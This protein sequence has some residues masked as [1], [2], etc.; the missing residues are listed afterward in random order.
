MAGR[1]MSNAERFARDLGEGLLPHAMGLAGAHGRPLEVHCLT[2]L[3]HVQRIEAMRVLEGFSGTRGIVPTHGATPTLISGT[4]HGGASL[5]GD[6]A[7]ELVDAARTF[8]RKQMFRFRFLLELRR[9][10][11]V[12]SPAGY[13][14]LSNRHGEALLS[15]AALVCQDVSHVEM[16]LPLYDRENVVFCR[17]DLSD[18]RGTVGELLSDDALRI[19]IAQA[20]RRSYMNWARD[21][22]RHLDD[23]IEAHVREAFQPRSR[24]TAA[25]PLPA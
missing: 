11:V 6:V 9:H 2:G 14:E 21:W 16:M 17:P 1:R 23:G 24:A 10:R 20:G 3:S 13:G 5:P 25:T 7:R 4:E 15:G 8:W 22:R 18:L 19:R 12:F